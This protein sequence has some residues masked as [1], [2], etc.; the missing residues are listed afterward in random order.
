MKTT[1]LLLAFVAGKGLSTVP[2]GGSFSCPDDNTCCP[3][4]RRRRRRRKPLIAEKGGMRRRTMHRTTRPT[5]M[6]RLIW[7]RKMQ[8]TRKLLPTTKREM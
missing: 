1:A 2:C 4:R 7:T 8:R 5:R 3:R 6:R